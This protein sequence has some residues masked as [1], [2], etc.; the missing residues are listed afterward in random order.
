V[1]VFFLVSPLRCSTVFLVTGQG[2]LVFPCF[3]NFIRAALLT[4]LGF[5][6]AI[7]ILTRAYP[8]FDSATVLEF[9]IFFPLRPVSSGGPPFFHWGVYPKLFFFPP[10]RHPLERKC[11]GSDFS[12]FTLS[13][14]VAERYK[15]F[16]FLEIRSCFPPIR[17]TFSPLAFF[18]DSF[19]CLRSLPTDLGLPPW[20][21]PLL[22]NSP[23]KILEGVRFL[24][25]DS[26]FPCASIWHLLWA[27][28]NLFPGSLLLRIYSPL[29]V[30]FLLADLFFFSFMCPN[31]EHLLVYFFPR[32]P[33]P[34]YRNL[35]VAFVVLPFR[36]SPKLGAGS[37]DRSSPIQPPPPPL[38]MYLGR[39]RTSQR[40]FFL[41]HIPAREPR[42][43][44]ASSCP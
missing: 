10:L 22:E 42:W 17:M 28:G 39:T 15:L 43:T 2:L 16:P 38:R 12:L 3:L 29:I 34:R 41:P 19:S 9:K 31:A 13:A 32:S 4:L 6:E 36:T 35:R 1:S 40:S 23:L 14:P 18:W 21:A 26:G 24:I 25:Y 33:C 8:F 7:L 27:L 30:F 11:S 37:F 44:F 20:G 5:V